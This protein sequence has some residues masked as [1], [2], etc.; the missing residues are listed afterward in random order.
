MLFRSDTS[1]SSLP[2]DQSSIVTPQTEPINYTSRFDSETLIHLSDEAITHEGANAITLS[3]D[4]I[5]YE[6]KDTYESGLPYGEGDA[7]DKHSAEE[8]AA[9]TVVTITQPGAYRITGTLSAGQ[10]K[11]DLGEDAY[12]DPSAVV[13]LILDNAD[14]T[15]TVAPAIVFYNVYECDGDWSVDT[16]SPNVDTSNAGAVVILADGSENRVTG[17]HVAKI[18][19]DKEGKKKLW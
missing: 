2:A 4:I 13:E 9:H 14:I 10:I 17:S 1:S 11:I 18:Y 5:Y 3:H 12:D 7:D 15:C 6:D 8:A 19:K 16:A